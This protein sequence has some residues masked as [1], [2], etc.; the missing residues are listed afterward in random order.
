VCLCLGFFCTAN[1]FRFTNILVRYILK[2][3]RHTRVTGRAH[4]IQAA[5][6]YYVYYV[7]PKAKPINGLRTSVPTFP[8]SLPLSLP[9]PKPSGV[10]GW[11]VGESV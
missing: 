7:Y 5:M 6:S 1:S 2:V 9:P 3:K 4:R 11:D 10:R 8:P